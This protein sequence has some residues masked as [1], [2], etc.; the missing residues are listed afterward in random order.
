M[1]RISLILSLNTHRCLTCVCEIELYHTRESIDIAWL[2]N[3]NW[4]ILIITK[5]FEFCQRVGR[6]VASRGKKLGMVRRWQPMISIDSIVWR[7]L[8]N[9]WCR[10]LNLM[11][12]SLSNLRRIAQRHST[13]KVA[14]GFQLRLL[15]WD[16]NPYLLILNIE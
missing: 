5:C 10:S 11:Y 9:S 1:S 8:M 3:W 2:R 15:I 12:N 6:H 14:L 4:R 16:S 13:S 7:N